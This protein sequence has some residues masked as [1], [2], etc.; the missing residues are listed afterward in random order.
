MKKEDESFGLEPAIRKSLFDKKIE[1]FVCNPSIVVNEKTKNIKDKV[2][3]LLLNSSS[4]DIAVSYVVWS[5]LS[6]IYD[7]LKK[8][9]EDSRLIL[10][11]EGMVTDPTS[12]SELKKL[13][14]KVK[15]YVPYRNAPGFH[16]KSYM[17]KAQDKITLLVGSS[18]ISSRAFGVVHEMVVEIK[19]NKKGFLVQKYRNVFDELWNNQ[20]SEALTDDFINSYKDLYNQKKEFDKTIAINLSKSREIDPNYMQKRLLL[21]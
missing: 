19:A 6:L 5:G 12:L 7:D 9:G 10:T 20:Y 16:L 1:S 3:E 13:D 4:V 17:F 18:N 15:I 8:F 2:Q 14:M 11:T 21:L